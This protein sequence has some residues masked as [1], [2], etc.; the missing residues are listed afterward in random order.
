M[1]GT[2]K[3]VSKLGKGSRFTITIPKR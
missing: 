2:I 1:G 3:A